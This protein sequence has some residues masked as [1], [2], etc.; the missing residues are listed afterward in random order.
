MGGKILKEFVSLR[1]KLYAFK[2]ENN[3]EVKKAKDVKK[4]VINQLI[5][6]KCSEKCN[7]EDDDDEFLNVDVLKDIKIE[8]NLNEDDAT[9]IND[10]I[11][12]INTVTE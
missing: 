1:P 9:K 8:T 3:D 10:E 4:Y 12:N 2:T 6:M 5:L 7:C 11:I